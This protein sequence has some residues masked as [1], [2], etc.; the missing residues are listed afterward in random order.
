MIVIEG[1]VNAGDSS[2]LPK[3][4]ECIK[5][6]SSVTGISGCVTDAHAFPVSMFLINVVK[7]VVCFTADVGASTTVVESAV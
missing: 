6:L 5:V 1:S 3:R 4:D 7:S 2:L